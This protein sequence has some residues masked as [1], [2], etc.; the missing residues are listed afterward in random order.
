MLRDFGFVEDYPHRFHFFSRYTV[1]VLQ[2]SDGTLEAKCKKKC[3]PR[4]F[5]KGQLL[6]LLRVYDDE[7]LL[8]KDIVPENEFKTILAYH[9]ALTVAFSSLMDYWEEHREEG[10]SNISRKYESYPV[11]CVVDS[12]LPR[13]L[14]DDDKSGDEDE[15]DSN[16]EDENEKMDEE[17]SIIQSMKADESNSEL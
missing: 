4:S 13:F 6:R 11:T 14:L 5:V 8:S 1:E 10:K 16:D 7:I 17:N 3:P 12:I 9:Y 15:D 2:K